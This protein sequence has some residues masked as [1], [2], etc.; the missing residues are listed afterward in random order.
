M[1]LCWSLYGVIVIVKT[2]RGA[3]YNRCEQR[4]SA[5]RIIFCDES[6]QYVH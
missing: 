6:P 4:Y 3:C 1:A 2:V 5:F